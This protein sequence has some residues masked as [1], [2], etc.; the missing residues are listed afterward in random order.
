MNRKEARQVAPHY[1]A[2]MVLVLVIV[3]GLDAVTG[4]PFWL[5]VVL[6]LGIGAVYR[7]LVIELGVAPDPWK[8]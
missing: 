2:V 5:G 1:V 3:A 4:I 6:A 8:D 7:P